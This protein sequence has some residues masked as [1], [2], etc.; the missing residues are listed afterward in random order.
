MRE[1]ARTTR[2]PSV[3]FFFFGGGGRFSPV[4]KWLFFF[5]RHGNTVSD[6]LPNNDR[7]INTL[8]SLFTSIF[9]MT[10]FLLHDPPPSCRR[11]LSVSGVMNDGMRVLFVIKRKTTK[12]CGAMKRESAVGGTF[13]DGLGRTVVGLWTPPI[14]PTPTCSVAAGD[15]H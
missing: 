9:L 15:R 12:R 13:W 10:S 1:G 14:P 2:F 5:R 4:F 7:Y 11:W 6:T 8:K 3:F